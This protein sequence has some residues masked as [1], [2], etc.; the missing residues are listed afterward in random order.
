V[1]GKPPVRGGPDLGQPGRGHHVPEPRDAVQEVDRARHRAPAGHAVQLSAA[2]GHQDLI[3]RHGRQLNAPPGCGH[4]K[5]ASAVFLMPELNF[6]WPRAYGVVAQ[7]PDSQGHLP[8]SRIGV[9]SSAGH[10]ANWTSGLCPPLSP[11]G[12]RPDITFPAATRRTRGPVSAG[13]HEY[14]RSTSQPAIRLS[15]VAGA[16]QRGLYPRMRGRDRR[17]RRCPRARRGFRSPAPGK[18]RP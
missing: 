4:F 11:R 12:S 3:Q 7:T 1:R 14:F 9:K 10:S 8:R 16:T 2:A 17:L 18:G 6:A 5:P 13:P 15:G